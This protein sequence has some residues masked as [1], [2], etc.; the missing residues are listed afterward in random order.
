MQGTE[1]LYFIHF[2]M[3]QKEN[4]RQQVIITADLPS[5]I[6]C[7]YLDARRKN[8]SHVYY[9]GNQDLMKLDDIARNGGSFKGVIYED[10]DKDSVYVTFDLT[11]IFFQC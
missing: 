1:K 7:Q 10:I 11:F 5:D 3:F 6:K 4:N 9:L 8:P 2:P